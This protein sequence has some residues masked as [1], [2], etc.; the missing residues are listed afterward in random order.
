[1]IAFSVCLSV[2]LSVSVSLSE[3]ILFVSESLLSSVRIFSKTFAS[4]VASAPVLYH[5]LA[6][7]PIINFLLLSVSF[8]ICFTFSLELFSKSAQLIK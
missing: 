3:H 1:M 2:R 8:Y 7:F 6:Y 4:F 5:I